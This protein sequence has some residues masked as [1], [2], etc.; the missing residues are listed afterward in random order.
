[1]PAKDILQEATKLHKMSESLTLLAE[2]HAPVAEA[3]VILAGTVRNSANLLEILV[4]LRMGPD[5]GLDAPIN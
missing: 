2:Q 4:Q 5:P 3:L 1:V